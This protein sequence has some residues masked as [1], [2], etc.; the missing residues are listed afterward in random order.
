M[1]H[2]REVS[3]STAIPPTSTSDIVGQHH[4][5]GGIIFKPAFTET[6]NPRHGLFQWEQLILNYCSMFKGCCRKK[7][8]TKQ[9]KTKPERI[10]C[11]SFFGL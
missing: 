10:V 1:E 8:K 5:I 7:N 9:N 11:L 4:K 3:T 6:R 2:W